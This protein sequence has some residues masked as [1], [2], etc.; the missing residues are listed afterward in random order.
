MNELPMQDESSLQTQLSHASEKLQALVRD[1]NRIDGQI[2]GLSGERHRYELLSQICGGITQLDEL[3]AADLFWGPSPPANARDQV[4]TALGRVDAFQK[5]I[6]EIEARRQSVLE[7]IE[8]SEATVELLE[9]D[10]YELEKRREEKKHEWVIEREVE[11]FPVRAAKMPWARGGE[12]D[13]RFRKS[14]LAALLLSLLLG[15]I[16]PLVDLP[17][18]D[19][20]EPEEIPDRFTRLIR[21]EPPVELPPVQPQ[22][23]R[24]D[25]LEPKLAQESTPEAT[26]KKAPDP[27]PASKGILAF[28][29]KFSSLADSRSAARLGAQARIRRAGEAATGR[30][31]RALITAQGPGT[32]GGIDVGELSRDVGSGGDGIEG[33]DIARATSSIAAIGAGSDRPLSDGP[34]LSRTDEEIQIVFDRHKAALYR[35]YN[36]QLRKDPTLQGQMVLRMTIEPDGTVSLCEVKSSDMKAPQL[37]AQVAARVRTFDFGAKDG[38]PAITILYPID[39]LPAT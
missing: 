28:R 10:L 35:L 14:L 16:F 34:G 8:Q 13:Q 21:Q 26:P 36:R 11:S 5:R 30:P 37:S 15:L 19:P 24:P 4:A 39:F 33:V 17:L 23:T 3:G 32:S 7:E 31:Q 27:A 2:A 38:I 9:D 12:D 20:W 25:E 22:P 18:P 29:E 1:L 6:D